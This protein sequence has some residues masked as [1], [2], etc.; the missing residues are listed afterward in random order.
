MRVL[1]TI[2]AFAVAAAALSGCMSA[3]DKELEGISL[4]GGNAIAINSAL[5]I[6]DPWPAGVQETDLKVPADRG[7]GKVADGAGTGSGDS[8][9][10][11]LT[12]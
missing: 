9:T 11:G 6:I 1:K 3:E 12:N 5:Q 4:A 8:V 10:T 7:P 2:G